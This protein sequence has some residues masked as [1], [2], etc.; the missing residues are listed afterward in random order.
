MAKKKRGKPSKQT[1]KESNV[2]SAID[3]FKKPLDPWD[4]DLERNIPL[5][6]ELIDRKGFHKGFPEKEGSYVFWYGPN[7]NF[8]GWSITT[9]KVHSKLVWAVQNGKLDTEDQ[10]FAD[11]AKN[12]KSWGGFAYGPIQLLFMEEREVHAGLF[13]DAGTYEERLKTLIAAFLDYLAGQRQV[14]HVTCRKLFQ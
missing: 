11:R 7:Q 5:P 10:I 9:E 14:Q 3:D 4:Q 2:Q 8:L 1:T 13:Q 6:N 12:G